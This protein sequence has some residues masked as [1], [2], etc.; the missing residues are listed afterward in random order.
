[1]ENSKRYAFKSYKK[2]E[3][4]YLFRPAYVNYN[5]YIHTFRKTII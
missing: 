4:Y 5:V 1:M 2:Y 3:I